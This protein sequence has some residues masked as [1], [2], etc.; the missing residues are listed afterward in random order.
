MT[1]AFTGAKPITETD[2]EQQGVHM[3]MVVED[4]RGVAHGDGEPIVT[5]TAFTYTRK[6]RWSFFSS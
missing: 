2:R 4:R 1:R 6:S 3:F 5:S